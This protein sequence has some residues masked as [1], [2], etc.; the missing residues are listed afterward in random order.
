MYVSV[1]MNL[2]V[3][4]SMYESLCM[5]QYFCS[6]CM[7]QC[8]C[9]LAWCAFVRVCMYLTSLTPQCVTKPHAQSFV[10]IITERQ[11]DRQTQ[12][13]RHTD[14]QTLSLSLSHT[15]TH[16]TPHNRRSNLARLPAVS[17]IQNDEIVSVVTV[18]VSALIISV[19]D[20]YLIFLFIR[21]CGLSA[22]VF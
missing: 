3:C 6:L 9:I 5:C 2:Y 16:R 21:C 1:C 22:V 4:H 8:V 15:H 14:T 17:I 20:Y 13:H 11:T 19:Y 7:C 10:R 18:L 12:T